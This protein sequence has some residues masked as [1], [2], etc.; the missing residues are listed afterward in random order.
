MN[1][2]EYGFDLDPEDGA[3]VIIIKFVRCLYEI[4]LIY[5]LNCMYI[6]YKDNVLVIYFNTVVE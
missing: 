4:D 1:S 2:G 6:F 5:F 3:I